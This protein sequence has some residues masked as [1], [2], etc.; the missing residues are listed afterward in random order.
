[1][2][3]HFIN[4]ISLPAPN[5]CWAFCFVL[6]G[7]EGG[8]G[9]KQRQRNL[10]LSAYFVFIC[11]VHVRARLGTTKLSSFHSEGE[12]WKSKW[13]CFTGGRAGLSFGLCRCNI[14][15]KWACSDR[16]SVEAVTTGCTTEYFTNFFYV[17]VSFVAFENSRIQIRTQTSRSNTPPRPQL[18]HFSVRRLRMLS[19]ADVTNFPTTLPL[20]RGLSHKNNKSK[21]RA[22]KRP[23]SMFVKEFSR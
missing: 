15:R 23:Q 20:R 17:F 1:M 3:F 21:E 18:E 9:M 7:G 22:Q 4:L 12:I 8:G 13:K 5:N 6:V 11:D 2:P 10:K 16:D 14:T 19:K